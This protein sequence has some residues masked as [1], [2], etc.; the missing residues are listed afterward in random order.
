MNTSFF[1]SHLI[2]SS[3][4]EFRL[5][6]SRKDASCSKILNL[7]LLFLLWKEILPIFWCS[8]LSQFWISKEFMSFSII[9]QKNSLHR[10]QISR[11]SFLTIRFIRIWID[12]YKNR[13]S[14]EKNQ[15]IS[16][17]GQNIR[18]C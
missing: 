11:L 6:R 18:F 16:E 9:R 14:K 1:R 17:K 12:I 4:S 8:M 7:F 10:L 5:F 2:F 3:G 15:S 13:R